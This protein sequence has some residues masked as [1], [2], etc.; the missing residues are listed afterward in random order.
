MTRK[1][2]YETDIVLGRRYRDTQTGIEGTATAIGFF[3]YGCERVTLEAVVQGKIE[4]YSF[5]APRVED[6]ESQE[7]AVSLRT[8]GPH[9]TPARTGS[10]SPR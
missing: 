10:P 7:R 1:T 4:E 8:G 5:D 3:Q 9:R 6:I 2:R